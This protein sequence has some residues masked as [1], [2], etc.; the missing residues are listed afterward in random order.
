[1][2]RLNLNYPRE[3][4]AGKCSR[5]HMFRTHYI[6]SYHILMFTKNKVISQKLLW[7]AL[8]VAMS[9]LLRVMGTMR[10]T[11]QYYFVWWALC[12]AMSILLRV[13]GTM[14]V[15]CQYYFVWWALCV[16]MSILL[17]VMGTVRCHVNI[18]SCDG[19]YALPC[20]YYFVW[21]ALCVA[22]SILLRVIGATR[23]HVNIITSCD[24]AL[25]VAMLIL[26]CVMGTMRC[27]VN[28]YVTYLFT[29]HIIIIIKYRHY[30]ESISTTDKWWGILSDRSYRPVRS[31]QSRRGNECYLVAWS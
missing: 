7:W 2:L 27:H 16:A 26:L 12:V 14:R 19:H 3:P 24:G 15:P 1:M 11:C 20:Q 5:Y 10:C 4:F 31:Q 13:M 30:I 22:M 17:R 25:R 29:P 9:I 23:C 28:G 18:T 6:A 8:C 21:W